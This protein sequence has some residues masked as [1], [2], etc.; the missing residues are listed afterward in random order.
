MFSI[1]FKT[2][3]TWTSSS[4]FLPFTFHLFKSVGE[5]SIKVLKVIFEDHLDIGHVTSLQDRKL[6]VFFSKKYKSTEYHTFTEHH[7]KVNVNSDSY[8]IYP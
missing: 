1:C 3:K 4:P 2:Y 5:S 7:V 8:P 6:R